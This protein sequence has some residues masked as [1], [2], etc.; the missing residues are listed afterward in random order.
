M[1]LTFP[2]DDP[3]LEFHTCGSIHVEG[4]LTHFSNS[5]V[6]SK[7]V[8]KG[9]LI[10]RPAGAVFEYEC[11]LRGMIRNDI[12]TDQRQVVLLPQK[13][14]KFVEQL[15][16][17]FGVIGPPHL[18]VQSSDF[19]R[20]KLPKVSRNGPPQIGGD[21]YHNNGGRDQHD[22]NRLLFQSSSL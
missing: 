3:P 5:A 18:R 1:L 4:S 15:E 9:A 12:R 8:R 14:S 13:E 20:I 7:Q 2:M 16:T 11:G 21:P 10:I 17:L 22:P 19:T 6:V